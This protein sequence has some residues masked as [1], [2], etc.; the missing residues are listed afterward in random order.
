M[1]LIAG[2]WDVELPEDPAEGG[3]HVV[4]AG[5]EAIY[6]SGRVQYDAPTLIRIGDETESTE[7]L[8]RAYEGVIATPDRRLQIMDMETEVLG[9][10]PV[11]ADQTRISVFLSDLRE[12][13]EILLVLT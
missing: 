5:P 9:E 2:D 11:A 4:V 3:V 6:V 10:V 13:D 12:P 7:D 1:I 8:T